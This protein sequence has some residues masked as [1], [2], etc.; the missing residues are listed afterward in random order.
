MKPR[1]AV[2]GTGYWGKNLV[3]NFHDLDV[4]A[5][6][7]DADA[8]VLND[9]HTRFQV[10]GV[11]DPAHVF[12]DPSLTAVAI[13]TPATTHYA[14][15]KKALEAGKDVF[16]EKPL[17]LDVEEG[18]AL[19]ALARE[20]GRI[21]MVGHILQYH[22]AAIKLKALVD[23]GD[24]GKLEFIHSSR[25]NI[26]KVRGEEN[27]LWSFAPHDISLILWLLHETPVRVDAFGGD[28]LQKG[29]FDTSFTTLD[30][31]S[32]V[33]AQLFV[34]WLHPF[35]EQRLVVV[36]EKQMAV[37]DDL[38]DPKLLLYPHR[39]EWFKRA[40]IIKKADGIPVPTEVREPLNEELKEFMA[41]IESRRTPKTDAEEGLRV[42]QVIQQA[43]ASLRQKAG[44]AADASSSSPVNDNFF[45]HA[46]AVVD[47]GTKIAAGSK[48]WHFSHIGANVTIGQN[49]VI[50]QNVFIADGVSMGDRCK[51]Q[52][53]V[54]L[55]KGVA[56]ENHVFCGPSCV[57]TNVIDP[58]AHIE[59][60]SE[61]RPTRVK[62]GATIGANATILCGHTLGKFCLI[63]AG[64]VVTKDIPDHAL[65]LGV[66]AQVVGWVCQCGKNLSF[67][68]NLQ[69]TC[70][71]CST[72]Y[73]KDEAGVHSMT[74]KSSQVPEEIPVLDL[75]REYLYLKKGIDQAID[76]TLDHQQWILG[77]EVAALEER[78]ARILKVNHA[79]GVSS[80]TDALVLS[81][82]VLAI[83]TKGK[84]FFDPGDEIITTPFTFIATGDAIV[85]AGATP[86]F[87]DIDP[88]TFNLDMDQA[89]K[90]I[91]PRTVGIIPVH[92]FGLACDLD[93]VKSMAHR[94]R[95]FVLEDVAQSMGGQWR[96]KPLGSQGHLGAFSF[97]PSK[98]LGG[99]GDGG[100]VATNDAELDRLVR[101]LLKHG[102]KDKSNADHVGYNSRLDTLQAAVLLAKLEALDD[103]NE[104]RREIARRYREGLSDVP[105][106][107]LPAEIAGAM[108]VFNQFTIRCKKREAL[109][110]FLKDQGI[111]SMVYYST[112]LHTMRV[113]K[114]RS[115]TIGRLTEA[116]RAAEEVLS[117][118]IEP[119]LHEWEV[120]KVIAAIRD[121]AQ[122]SK[123]AKPSAKRITVH[124]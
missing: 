40:P 101:M 50:G 103:F 44:Y 54:S 52:N 104:K 75:R 24:L 3:R 57:F 23:N 10:P 71:F 106:I 112:P 113:F 45:V 6:V 1:V 66:P 11:S 56:L 4:L 55:Y 82:R 102:G 105:E 121:F 124:S 69:A 20:R 118:P 120:D 98:N 16:V 39:I 43:Q 62:E 87:V 17:S 32:G 122:R 92:L 9:F 41:C 86:V 89:E 25:L 22:P 80:G 42:L 5:A 14:L 51:I 108:H 61:Y 79:I 72:R 95:L 46:T 81:L 88:H 65:A 8:A 12:N 116:E 73:Q 85:R 99:F 19:A 96:G 36:G 77:P 107:M 74:E 30:F 109:R 34:S 47:P 76:A 114:G 70:A 33:K 100:L 2:I 48:I 123:Q 26:G 111:Q 27:I 83:Q 15:V 37:F 21:L 35:K 29:I 63:G 31:T 18:R 38:A 58:R 13:A 117:L 53:N 91:T 28:Y 94:H 60:K 93:R 64:A 115:K 67:D 119:L 68:N 49:C 7:C 84:E 110:S 90:S 97:F 59:R 78:L